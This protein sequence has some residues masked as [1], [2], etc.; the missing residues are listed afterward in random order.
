MITVDCVQGSPEW[1]QAR[2]GKVTASRINDVLAKIKTGEAADRRNYRAQ[3]IAEI[4]TGEPAE[5]GFVSAEMKWGTE[6]EPYARA[7][8]ECKNGVLVDQVGMVIHPR[9]ERGAASPDG[10]VDPDGLVEIKCPN[11]A[12]HLD[13]ILAG[14]APAKYQNQMLWQMA[15]TE[16][17][18]CDFVS[19]DPR[20][21]EEFQLFIVRFFRDDARIKAM[22]DEVELFLVSAL[23]TIDK[24]EEAAKKK[25]SE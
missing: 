24:L 25:A 5:T 4:L 17:E 13:Y 10:L 23:Q 15:C 16:R 7:A 12:T 1:L 14:E 9:I 8:Y 6:Q 2:A 20:L 11:T 3:I 21:P 19:F 18:W 22:E